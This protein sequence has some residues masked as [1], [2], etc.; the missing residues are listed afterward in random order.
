MA[1]YQLMVSAHGLVQYVIGHTQSGSHGQVT[2]EIPLTLTIGTRDRWSIRGDASVAG[3]GVLPRA[4]T[5]SFGWYQESE[6]GLAKLRLVSP[7]S[8][9]HPNTIELE[10][11]TQ[12]EPVANILRSPGGTLSSDLNCSGCYPGRHTCSCNVQGYCTWVRSTNGLAPSSELE[13]ELDGALNKR[14]AFP[15]QRSLGEKADYEEQKLPETIVKMRPA[16]QDNTNSQI[17]FVN[18]NIAMRPSLLLNESNQL[19]GGIL[20]LPLSKQI[21]V[22]D[23][24]F[25]FRK[26]IN[27]RA[28]AQ[29]DI[30]K[31]YARS[32]LQWAWEGISRRSWT[33]RSP[34]PAEFAS[35]VLGLRIPPIS[36]HRGAM[37][38]EAK[39]MGLS[40][41]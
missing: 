25:D 33:S 21:L 41:A 31:G 24:E 22:K 3:T 29:Y 28:V 18:W 34:F 4:F 9:A 8:I 7:Q 16:F 23:S 40:L 11:G 1:A 2:Y 37:Q 13:T 39:A 35:L 20:P 17:D 5:L 6:D 12:A 14:L 27:N 38:R 10:L 32:R 36:V 30:K 15:F 19:D 26:G